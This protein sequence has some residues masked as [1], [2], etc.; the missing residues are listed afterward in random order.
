MTNLGV[1]DRGWRIGLW[2]GFRLARVWWWF[3]RPEHHGV[4]VAIWFNGEVLGV[5]QSY[6]PTLTFPG[7]GIDRGEDE[8]MAAERELREEIGLIVQR[9]DLVLIQTMKL[10]W[11]YRHDHVRIFELHLRTAPNLI[12]DNREIVEASFMS[13]ECMLTETPPPF[14]QAYLLPLMSIPAIGETATSK[15]TSRPA[16]VRL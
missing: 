14:V 5:R 15:Q 2:L 16:G 12:L 11:D 10:K 8:W 1:L 4:V 3:R 6:R 13:P 7:G 9:E